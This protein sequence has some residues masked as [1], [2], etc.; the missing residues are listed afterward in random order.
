[1]APVRIGMS[2]Q[3]RTMFTVARA[4]WSTTGPVTT[5]FVEAI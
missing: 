5:L 3:L 2:V 1:M 4:G